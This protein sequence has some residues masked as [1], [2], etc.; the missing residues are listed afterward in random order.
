MKKRKAHTLILG[1]GAAGLSAAVRLKREGINDILVVS[2]GLSLGT[3]IN[4]GSDKQTYYKLGM[5]GAQKDSLCDAAE[6]YTSGGGMHGDLALV[7]AALSPRAFFNLVNLGVPFPHDELGE[8]IGYKTDHDPR[9]RATSCGPYTS[10]EMCR[11]LIAEVRRLNIPVLENRVVLQLLTYEEVGKNGNQSH[12][13]N[14]DEK[15]PEDRKMQPKN[16]EKRICGFIA[17]DSLSGELE[18][19]QAE[20]VIFAVGGPG[21]LY[22]T[23]VYPQVHTGAIGLALMIGAAA[24]GLPESQFGLASFT[25]VSDRPQKQEE[26]PDLVPTAQAS[27]FRWNVSGTFMQVLPR[28]IS[29][30]A[31]GHSNPKEFLRDY[32]N[33]TEEM[34]SRVFLKGYQ[35]PFDV[36]KARNGSS[37]IDLI[38]HYE[39]VE[40][41]RRVFLDFRENPAGTDFDRLAPEARDYLE[42]SN[43]LFGT[44]FDR[45]KKMN[46]GAISLYRDHGIDLETEPLEIAVCAQHNNG[47]LAGTIWYESENIRHF[48]PIGEVNGSHGVARPGG[49]ALNAG[50]VGAFRAA[51]FIAHRYANST[52]DSKKFE[53]ALES[54]YR[55]LSQALALLRKNPRSWQKDRSV[56]QKRMS[57]SAAQFRSYLKV[58]QAVQQ[59]WEQVRELLDGIPQTAPEKILIETANQPNSP[60]T[61]SRSVSENFDL[62]ATPILDKEQIENLRNRQLCFAHAAYLDAILFQ[63]ESGAGSRGSALVTDPNGEPIHPAL[64][65]NWT[66]QEENSEFKELALISTFD[67]TGGHHHWE[68][69]RPIPTPDEW[70]ENV[71]RD[72]R[73]NTIFQ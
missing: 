71:W 11:A 26:N 2:E 51:E 4:T 14:N 1:S 7:E 5:Y 20:N 60:M 50:Q 57:E 45:L 18:A 70:F 48:F 39:T 15:N 42:K 72:Y 47:G 56:F 46:P 38:V 59:A 53:Q 69:C 73:E 33:S 30:E 55:D 64:P 41:G 40:R 12:C 32:F 66:I 27:V 67:L 3:S 28:F 58:R 43:A 10:R 19:F 9:R 44:P 17:A 6:S 25:N 36:R 8:F 37:L 54:G 13:R 52:I 34:N 16:G 65:Q 24:R 63:I 21:G 61:N 22:D 29:T 31:D 23:S 62:S 49:S 35:W 68:N